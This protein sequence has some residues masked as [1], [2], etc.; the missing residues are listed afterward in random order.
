MASATAVIVAG[1]RGVRMASAI[2]KQYL[3]LGDR[4][5]LAHT[6][7]PFYTAAAI[8]RI[9]LVVPAS[10][11]E[12]CRRRIVQSYGFSDKVTMAEGGPDRQASVYNGLLAAER[13]GGDD[14]PVLIH[15]GVR[16][17]VTDREIGACLDEVARSGACIL[18]TPATETLKRAGADHR[19]QETVSRRGI[20]MAQT[21]QAFAFR[22]IREAHERARGEGVSGTDDASLV[23]RMGHPVT[24]VFGTRRNIKITAPDD[25]W[26]AEA[27]LARL[28]WGSQC[29]QSMDDLDDPLR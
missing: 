27:I 25:L 21:P 18:A 19:I 6:I 2:R 4:P 10:D 15:D 1:G 24:I 29:P 12:D 22:L 23:E 26:M 13:P 17:F 14:H 3:I 16:P 28:H 20:W 7:Q 11:T 5:I 9:V 8:E